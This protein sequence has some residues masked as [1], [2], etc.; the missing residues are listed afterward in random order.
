MYVTHNNALADI[1]YQ[2]ITVPKK[3]PSRYA[4]VKVS[5]TVM[6]FD[7]ETTSYFLTPSGVPVAYNYGNSAMK[8]NNRFMKKQGLMYHWQIAI[9]SDHFTGRTWEELQAFFDDL[10]AACPALKIIYVHDLSFEFG[11]L[12]N[13]ISFSGEGDK[14]LAREAHRIISAYTKKYNIEFRCSYYLTQ[15]SLDEWG[16]KYGLPKV[17]GYDF[18]QL[19][20]P[21]TELTPEELAYCIRDVD[22]IIRG[23]NDYKIKYKHVYNIP[24]TLTGEIRRELRKVYKNT[25][26]WYKTCEKLQPFSLK[27]FRWMM[28]AFIGGCVIAAPAYKDETIRARFIF[29]D[30]ASAY[31][32]ALISE[33]YPIKKFTTVTNPAAMHR[34]MTNPD[35]TYIVEFSADNVNTRVPCLFLSSLKL[36][37]ADGLEVVNGRIAYAKHLRCVLSKPDYQTFLK[38]YFCD[39]KI[40]KIKV[41]E[42]G[43]LPDDFRRYVIKKYREKVELKHAD[44]EVYEAAK[45]ALN[46][47]FGIN[48]QKL[49]EDQACFD[50]DH[51]NKD[52]EPEPW[53]T[54]ELTAETFPE[55]LHSVLYNEKGQPKK[56]FIAAQIGIFCCSYARKN[57]WAAILGET[58]PGVYSCVD[59]VLYTDTDSVKMLWSPEAD[60]Y[61][62]KYNAEIIEKH[63][64]IAE[65]LGLDPAELSPLDD[66][67]VPRPIGVYEDDGDATEFKTLGS[68]K[69]VYRDKQDGQ[70]HLAVSGVPKAAVV[71]LHD[72][73]DNFRDG[74]IFSAEEMHNAGIECKMAAFY[75]YRQ[76]AVTFPDGYWDKYDY[77]VCLQPIDYTLSKSYDNF[78]DPDEFFKTIFKIAKETKLLR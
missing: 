34:Y 60:A 23:I 75:Q 52:G 32:W 53:Y 6:S 24:V 57:L 69:Y 30:E 9:G 61:F 43:Y 25:P 76:K 8:Y 3:A 77:S 51:T 38:C 72:D 12:P 45:K 68:K 19:R 27:S 67:G 65:Q 46:S 74:F 41:S 5:D 42:L 71:C 44:T 4:G 58:E 14:V 50:V 47:L 36:L 49:F 55:V 2:L 56:L 66:E 22:I 78:S 10:R 28:S 11:F 29:K 35:M 40:H 33:R 31:P 7:V 73:I 70:L 39:V 54:K 17:E 21:L 26:D 18:R 62:E 59:D 13:I 37:E 15:L 16:S 64:I 20:T 1:D 63:K 48:T